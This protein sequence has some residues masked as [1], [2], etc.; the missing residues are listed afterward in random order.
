LD[1]FKAVNDSAGH[2]TG[3]MVLQRVAKRIRDASG[4]GAMVLRMSGDEFAV[5]L[6]HVSAAKGLADR[7][8]D[9]IAR[10][11]AVNGHVVNLTASIGIARLTEGITPED[12]IGRANIALHNAELSGRNRQVLFDMPMQQR[13]SLRFLL[14]RD[15]RAA[16]ALHQGELRAALDL[17]QFVLEYQPHFHLDTRRLTGF[18]ALIRWCHPVR[19]LVG[20]A[21][22]IPLAEEIGLIGQIGNWVL[23]TACREAVRWPEDSQGPLL[24]S[25]NVS[26]H[27]LQEGQA[28]VQLVTDALSDAGLPPNRLVLE[29]TESTALGDVAPVFRGIRSL[30]VQLSVDDFGT[31]FS[32]LSHLSRF[33]FDRLKID[34]SF[35]HALGQV[36]VGNCPDGPSSSVSKRA[37]A[38]WMLRA[39]SGLGIGLGL[40]TMAEGV[41]TQTQENI[42]RLA[43]V[44]E[45]QGF[46]Y[47]RPI[48]QSAVVEFIERYRFG[49]YPDGGLFR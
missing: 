15:L 9:L 24:L 26:G 28:F 11:Y 37:Q 33:G 43:G 2:K 17:E 35:V 4:P 40:S 36:E 29:I 49:S 34:K 38:A 47:S 3:D 7:L 31:G 20:P 13:A 10:P 23:R 21:E 25:V 19:G 27:Q 6:P 8:L 48:A 45:V 46:F 44:T 5:L 30:G 16:I 41:E 42:L 14:E 18:E 1:R 39:V 12:L 22:F 32:S